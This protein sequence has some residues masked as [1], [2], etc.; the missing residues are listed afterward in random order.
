[1]IYGILLSLLFAV[2]T[3]FA[4]YIKVEGYGETEEEARK[5]ALRQI[6]ELVIAE[7][8]SEVDLRYRLRGE[9][10]DKRLRTS[11]SV[12]SKGYIRGVKFYDP[13]EIDGKYRVKAVWDE[14]SM[15]ATLRS[16]YMEIDTDPERLNK[17]QLRELIEKI[18]FL[19]A[20]YT[21]RP[22]EEIDINRVVG[23]KEEA[24]KRLNYSAVIFYTEPEDAVIRINGRVYEPFKP[25]YLPERMYVFRVESKGYHTVKG[26]FYA[27]K[28]DIRTI[29]I[30]LVPYGGSSKDRYRLVIEDSPV[31]VREIIKSKLEKFGVSLS[32]EAKDKIVFRFQHSRDSFGD[33][34]RH[35]IK[36]YAKVYKGNRVIASVTAET[37]YFFTLRK[38][39]WNTIQKK[40]EKVLGNVIRDLLIQVRK[41][42]EFSYN[43]SGFNLFC[44]PLFISFNVTI[45]SFISS[46]PI[47][48]A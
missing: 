20:L 14:D 12:K 29:E 42:E 22:L 17:E 2:N 4:I 44:S 31:D 35:N 13:E 25:I 24:L 43:S 7:V 21:L 23:I 30:R 8:S 48:T 46:S 36:V 38:N 40:L 10:V 18:D 19:L 45:P 39:M 9:K 15:D 26:R 6:S 3:V 27:I 11:V 41:R 33:Y 28:G 1:M 37:G 47:I 5:D 16:L 34:I 32:G